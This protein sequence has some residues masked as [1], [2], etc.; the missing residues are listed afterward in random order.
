MFNGFLT[1]PWWSYILITLVFTHIT[2][3]SVTL[4]LHRAQAHRAISIHPLASHF[5]RF[6]LWLTTGINTKEWVAVH[7]KHHAKVELEEDP[8]S[9]QVYGINKVLWD[10]VELYR[11]ETLQQQTLDEYGHGTP[12]D[13]LE[14]NLYARHTWTGIVSMLLINFLLF[15]FI[16]ISIWAIQMLWIPLFAAGVING[17]GHYFGYRNFDSPDASTNIIPIGI[18]IGGEEMHNNHHAFASSARF[19]IK[20]WE[21]DI[22]WLYIQVLSLLKLVEIKK[23][24]PRPKINLYKQA[25]DTDTVRAVINNRM[26]VMSDYAKRVVSQ[27]YKE[28]HSKAKPEA[29]PILNRL[30]HMLNMPQI[31][32][33]PL[34]HK[35]LQELLENNESLKIVYE[36]RQRLQKI[37]LEKTASYDNLM[38]DLQEWCKQA[39][40]SGIKALEDFAQNLRAYTLVTT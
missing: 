20:W 21:F 35:H 15:G 29:K 24:A 6:W 4:F 34:H 26:H 23:V 33:D 5:M 36:F 22:G 8:H 19:S 32:I 12:E 7:R 38:H 25:V 11:A 9:P 27:V 14:K 17:L 39:E 10:G 1:L 13:W 2:I 30:K 31:S 16:G 18:L 28:E 37:W 3:V 40:Q